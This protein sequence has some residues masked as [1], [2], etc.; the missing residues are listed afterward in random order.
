VLVVL[1][2][3]AFSHANHITTLSPPEMPLS[4]SLGVLVKEYKPTQKR[5]YSPLSGRHSAFQYLKY[6]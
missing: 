2:V 1:V 3:D 4:P 5:A 6:S